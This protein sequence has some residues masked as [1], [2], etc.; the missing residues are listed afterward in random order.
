MAAGATCDS[1]GV[2]PLK[3]KKKWRESVKY[4]HSRTDRA[5]FWRREGSVI[6]IDMVALRQAKEEDDAWPAAATRCCRRILQLWGCISLSSSTRWKPR[7]QAETSEGE[8]RAPQRRTGSLTSIGAVAE[9]FTG[10][11]ATRGTRRPLG[12][13]RN[14]SNFL[15]PVLD[16]QRKISH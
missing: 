14:C 16:R 8:S 5:R 12:G 13:C 1:A 4:L 9:L 2:G 7:C 15:L 3:E 10:T 11:V 6:I